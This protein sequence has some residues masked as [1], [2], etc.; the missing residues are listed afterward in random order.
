MTLAILVSRADPASV[1]IRDALLGEASWETRGDF[2]A[3]PLRVGPDLVIAEVEGL[4]LF[5]ESIGERLAAALGETPEAIFVA[6]KHKAASGSPSLTVHPVGVWGDVAEY[7]GKPRSFAPAPARRMAQA[8]RALAREAKGLRHAITYEVTHHGPWTG[9]PLAFVEVGSTE[10]EWSKPEPAR[11]VA[12]ALLAV[13]REP[14]G[15]EPVVLGLGGGHYAPKCVDLALKGRAA[16]GH[17]LPGY[18]IDQGVARETV[19]AALAATP[20]VAGYALDSRGSKNGY[21]EVR[22][23]LEDAG[24]PQLL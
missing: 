20:G 16:P 9:V 1:A 22:A 6:S 3:A 7:G 24:V 4:H 8:L 17:M 21:D 12:R 11:A 14:P 5:E 13:S 10:E 15:D 23:I 19:L 18:A 2:G